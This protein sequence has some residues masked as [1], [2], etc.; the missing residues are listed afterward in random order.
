MAGF[1]DELLL[2]S[3][4]IV[5]INKG[6]FG[7]VKSI[8]AYPINQIKVFSNQAQVLASNTPNG[9]PQIEIYFFNGSM[10]FGFENKR[11]A[12]N[13]IARINQLVTGQEVGINNTVK[14]TS[15]IV[16]D[17]L[18]GTVDAFK[19]AFGIGPKN[20]TAFCGA[21]GA[22]ISG[23]TGQLAKCPYCNAQQQL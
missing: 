17:A 2:T 7:K 21:C 4:N 16:A 9:S 19:G 15:G 13:W 18:S 10:K 1:T 20:T 11:D 6:T 8:Q 3:K 5:H 23:K 22:Q 12:A 14:T